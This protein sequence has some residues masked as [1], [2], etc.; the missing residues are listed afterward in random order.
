MLIKLICPGELYVKTIELGERQ[1]AFLPD[2]D[3]DNVCEVTEKA[4][5]SR[6]LG[7]DD[8]ESYSIKDPAL[9]TTAATVKPKKVEPKSA[10]DPFANPKDEMVDNDPVPTDEELAR[11]RDDSEDDKLPEVKK[12]N[13]FNGLTRKQLEA[14]YKKKFGKAPPKSA[15]DATLVARLAE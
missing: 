8:G 7:I 14:A 4:H 9:A 15:K 1:Y 6:L 13:E 12:G 10:D 11:S 2:K 3:G 5:L